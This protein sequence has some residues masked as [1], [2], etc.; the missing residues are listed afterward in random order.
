MGGRARRTDEPWLGSSLEELSEAL[1]TAGEKAVLIVPF[2]VI[3]DHLET[4]Y[5]VDVEAKEQ[6]ERLGICLERA[7]SPNTGPRFIEA[8]ASAVRSAAF[9]RGPGGRPQS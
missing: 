7:E 1:G 9:G 6:A 8:M 4:L 3:S 2:G 5:D